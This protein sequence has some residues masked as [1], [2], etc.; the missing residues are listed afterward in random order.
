MEAA[1]QKQC[2]LSN[3]IFLVMVTVYT[4][5]GYA[6]VDINRYEKDFESTN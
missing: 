6:L 3:K 5:F 1:A 4:R 2:K